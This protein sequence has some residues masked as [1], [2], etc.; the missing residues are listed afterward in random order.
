MTFIKAIVEIP[1]RADVEERY[2]ARVAT[3]LYQLLSSYHGLAR[4]LYAGGDDLVNKIAQLWEE[5]EAPTLERELSEDIN[6][7]EQKSFV[8]YHQKHGWNKHVPF[9]CQNIPL[10]E[11]DGHQYLEDTDIIHWRRKTQEGEKP[12]LVC[13]LL[14]YFNYDYFDAE[15]MKVLNGVIFTENNDS[16]E[17]AQKFEHVLER[18]AHVLYTT[19]TWN[20][21]CVRIERQ[22]QTLDLVL[23]T[24]EQFI[25]VPRER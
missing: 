19:R 17:V 4:E 20:G 12:Y 5:P 11:R 3:L 22:R 16:D 21:V 14:K 13:Y 7:E 10:Q 9:D 23:E 18:F 15:G 24:E 1:V 6:H 8:E 2:K 25:W